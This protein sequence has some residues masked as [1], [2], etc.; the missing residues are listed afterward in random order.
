MKMEEDRL[1]VIR[2]ERKVQEEAKKLAV[3]L[4]GAA[5]EGLG[6]DRL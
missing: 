2:L 4:Q 1:E 5:G 3:K 6:L